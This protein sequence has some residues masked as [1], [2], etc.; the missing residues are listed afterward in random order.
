V[1]KKIIVSIIGCIVIIMVGALQTSQLYGTMHTNISPDF[2]YTVKECNLSKWN[3]RKQ[4][5]F[6]SSLVSSTL[7]NFPV[8]VYEASDKDLK[9]NASSTG[10]DI[11]FVA[12]SVDWSSGDKE[13]RLPHEIELYKSSTGALYAWV[14][15][16][17]LS[18][19]ADTMIYMYY[20][21]TDCQD[22]YQNITSVWDGNYVMVQ[23]LNETSGSFTDSTSYHNDGIGSGT[24]TT[25]YLGEIAYAV[26]FN[27]AGTTGVITCSRRSSFIT[28]NLT[29]EAWFYNRDS[30]ITLPRI[31]SFEATSNN[32]APYNLYLGD[33][34]TTPSMAKRAAIGIGSAETVARG[35]ANSY[36]FNRWEYIAA[37]LNNDTNILQVYSN[38]AASGSSVSCTTNIANQSRWLLL[39]NNLNP[40]DSRRFNGTIDEVR[41]SKIDRSIS[42]INTTFRTIYMPTSFLTFGG[43]NIDT[44][45]AT[46]SDGNIT[47]STTIGG[48]NA[49]NKATSGTVYDT[50]PSI[51]V[52]QLYNGISRTYTIYRGYL[53]FDTSSIPD[54]ATITSATLSLYAN[55]DESTLCDF[56]VTI[57]NGQPNSPHNPLQTWDYDCTNYSGDGGTVNSTEFSTTGYKTITIKDDA[58]SWISKTGT[59]KLCLRSHRDIANTAPGIGNEYVGFYAQ[60]KG[61]ATRPKLTVTY[62]MP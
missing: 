23:H 55:R 2:S 53:F 28:K 15:I 42:W 61:R 39:G 49:C 10:N 12:S 60:E 45:Y 44:F 57:Q 59:T 13:D 38:G 43:Q 18:S 46:S 9:N 48:Y 26:D 20:N 47:K 5:Y 31:I 62:T 32:A 22:D 36:D 25:G 30:P 21:N 54:K 24:I 56:D 52:G 41:I 40:S 29:L 8:L 35:A 11:I 58:L 50:K 16:S 27:S 19:T 33:H 14:N 4:I 17:S 34:H 37:T 51:Y 3:Y 7:T 6:N 1:N